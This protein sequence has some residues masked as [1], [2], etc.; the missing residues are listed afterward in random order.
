MWWFIGLVT[1]H[2][3]P[4]C[5]L[6]VE[7]Q[8]T[9]ALIERAEQAF[10]D[11][12]EDTFLSLRERIEGQV[13]C[14]RGR[15]DKELL[16]DL[17]GYHALLAVHDEDTDLA[18]R[19]Y[20]SALAVLSN[21]KPS[22]DLMT[23]GSLI[24]ELYT[25]A[26]RTGASDDRFTLSPIVGSSYLVDGNLTT[27]AP[28]DRPFVLQRMA[29][30]GRIFDTQL[31]R[32]ASGEAPDL[33]PLASLTAGQD[34]IKIVYRKRGEVAALAIGGAAV[35]VGATLVITSFSLASQPDYQST[36]FEFQRSTNELNVAGWVVLGTGAAATIAGG[37][38]YARSPV[39]YQRLAVTPTFQGMQVAGRW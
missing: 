19:F 30:D 7:P 28:S 39:K 26:K 11:F 25:S 33:T 22:S 24:Q 34:N 12:E 1:A 20:A 27:L 23:E 10:V 2:A 15:A 9:Q 3:G 13:P 6:K 32:P 14:W 18:V 16:S 36:S 35:A 4:D 38:L 8:E 21:Y 5:S 29:P 31:V 17:H 37:I